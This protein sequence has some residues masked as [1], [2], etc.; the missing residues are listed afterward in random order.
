MQT[1]FIKT[2]YLSIINIFHKKEIVKEYIQANFSAEVLYNNFQSLYND[3][4]KFLDYANRMSS[5]T[6]K[7]NFDDFNNKPII[8]YLKKF[9]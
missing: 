4:N 2:N 8:D 9:S 5:Y 1:N 3:K 7:S 6:D